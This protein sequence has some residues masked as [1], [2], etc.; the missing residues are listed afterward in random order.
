MSNTYDIRETET[1][2]M[3]LCDSSFIKYIYLSLRKHRLIFE[4]LYLI[5][6]LLLITSVRHHHKNVITCGRLADSVEWLSVH[7]LSKDSRFGE[8]PS[9]F[10][11]EWKTFVQI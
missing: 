11:Y 6:C 8:V 10:Q 3:C 7:F 5:V 2:Y 1:V 9:S 4:R